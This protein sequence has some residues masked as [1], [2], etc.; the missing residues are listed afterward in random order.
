MG[1]EVNE[2][3]RHWPFLDPPNTAVF[4]NV[5]I[6]DGEDWIHFV[7]HDEEDGAWQFLPSRGQATMKEAAVV[8]LKRMV[9][10]EP[11]LEEL[12]DLPLGWHAWRESKN[13]PWTRAPKNAG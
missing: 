3:N 2:A 9:D 4:T 7:T 8:G 1:Q 10:I 11:R 6:L 13:E 5:R 12:A